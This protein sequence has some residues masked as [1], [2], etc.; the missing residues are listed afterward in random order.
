MRSIDPSIPGRKYICS[1][2]VIRNALPTFQLFRRRFA[3]PALF[4]FQL[5]PFNSTGLPSTAYQS[6]RRV[7]NIATASPANNAT[8][9]AISA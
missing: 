1:Y 2:E 4:T 7:Q 8:V 5:S 9:P 6:I 3:P